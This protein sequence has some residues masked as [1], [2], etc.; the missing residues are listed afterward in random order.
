MKRN[1]KGSKKIGAGGTTLFPAPIKLSVLIVGVSLPR[2][3]PWVLIALA[4]AAAPMR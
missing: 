3:A 2:K 4:H 1:M